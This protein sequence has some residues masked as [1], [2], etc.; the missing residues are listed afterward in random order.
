MDA[1]DRRRAAIACRPGRSR[2]P[3]FR[4][5]QAAGAPDRPG[6]AR[7]SA[8]AGAA[9]GRRGSHAGPL[10]GGD[11]P[12]LPA[13][14]RRGGRVPLAADPA[15]A[16]AAERADPGAHRRRPGRPGTDGG[17]FL[18][19][20][21]RGR[22]RWRSHAGPPDLGGVRGRGP[23]RAGRARDPGRQRG[24]R[25]A[26]AARPRAGRDD[27]GGLSA[28]LPDR[29]PRGAARPQVR[30]PGAGGQH[31]RVSGGRADPAGGLGSDAGA[32]GARPRPG[33]L[34]GRGQTGHRRDGYA[35]PRPA[36]GSVR[37]RPG[38]LRGTA[39]RQARPGR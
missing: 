28:R 5:R 6:R 27:P 18:R 39:P 4:V 36:A 13:G 12:G 7:G 23:A 35:F 17:G 38:R 32:G 34:R 15:Q 11:P 1:A 31:P 26:A 16:A 25:P 37:V 3:R 21:H 10:R 22:L 9:P 30:Q 14:G 8:A 24:R 29:G 33:A 2:L 19:R 20:D